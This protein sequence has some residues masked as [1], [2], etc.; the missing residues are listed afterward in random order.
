MQIDYRRI[1]EHSAS[2]SAIACN[3]GARGLHQEFLEDFGCA[4]GG[5]CDIAASGTR[6]LS[7]DAFPAGIEG[8]HQ[9]PTPEGHQAGNSLDAQPGHHRAVWNIRFDYNI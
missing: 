9:G 2:R 5:S 6:R 1:V 8:V 4:A 3:E 7:C